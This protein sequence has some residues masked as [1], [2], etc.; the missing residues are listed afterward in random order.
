MVKFVQ[1]KNHSAR[2]TVLQPSTI[3][4]PV[5][6]AATLRFYQELNDF[7]PHHQRGQEHTIHFCGRPTIKDV[8]EAQGVPHSQIDLILVNGAS[9]SFNYHVAGGERISVYPV[10]ERL[11]ITPL[12]RLRPAPLRQPRF[13][14]DVNVGKLARQLR[15]LGFDVYYQQHLDDPVLVKMAVEQHRIILTRDIG[16]LKYSA[17]THGY[18]VRHTQ[19][20]KQLV[21]VIT[22]L[23]LESYLHPF[24]RCSDCNSLLKEVDKQDIVHRLK[25]HTARLFT[26]FWCCPGCHKLYWQGSHY[27]RFNHMINTLFPARD[28]DP[29][30]PE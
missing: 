13:I 5:S 20:K 2:Q 22:A 25:P 27:H 26:K 6:H 11:D 7:L 18:W 4:A 9:V 3:H 24:T 12:I 10:F 23:Q 16:V 1:K 29:I 19:P 17:V 30:D 21:E 8:I 14:A 15:L 28:L